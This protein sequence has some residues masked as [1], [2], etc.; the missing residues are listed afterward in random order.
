[1]TSAAGAGAGLAGAVVVGAGL[2]GVAGFAGAAGLAG[3][4]GVV[5]VGFAGAGL[6]GA[7][8]AG[9]APCLIFVLISILLIKSLAVAPPPFEEF[10]PTIVVRYQI[11]KPHG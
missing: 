11:V 2:A 6:A 7:A 5:G 1:M 8:G 10:L 3:V 9:L 4:V